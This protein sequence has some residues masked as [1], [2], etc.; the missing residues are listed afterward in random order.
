MEVYDT[1]FDIEIKDDNSIN[2]LLSLH[3]KYNNIKGNC[4]NNIVIFK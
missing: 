2:K 1:A 3:D 4:L